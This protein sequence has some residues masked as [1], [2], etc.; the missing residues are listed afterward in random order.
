MNY[1]SQVLK[2]V[3]QASQLCGPPLEF[4]EG[5]LEKLGHALLN[6]FM[7][8]LTNNG[9]IVPGH[10]DRRIIRQRPPIAGVQIAARAAVEGPVEHQVNELVRDVGIGAPETLLR[11]MG[12]DWQSTCLRQGGGDVTPQGQAALVV[13]PN[14]A[15]GL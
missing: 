3:V 6:S 9:S 4:W 14:C 10:E 5:A 7:L 12:P 8:G 15:L 11:V 2:I 13:L 1:N